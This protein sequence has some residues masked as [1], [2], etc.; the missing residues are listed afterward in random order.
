MT[1]PA[2]SP[3]LILLAHPAL[4]RSHANRALRDAAAVQGVT[5]HD[6]YEAYPSHDIEIEAEQDLVSRH[7]TVVMQHPFYWYSVPPI[8]KEWMDLVLQHGWAYG[9][10]G[11]ALHGK[12]FLNALTTGDREASYSPAR[13]NRYTVR[14]FLAPI[15]M[16]ARLCGME[17]LPPFVVHGTQG[18]THD[19]LLAHA[20]DYRRLL[21]AL[22]DGR[23]DAAAAAGLPRI[24]SDLD[25]VIAT[26]GSASVPI[27]PR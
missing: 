13:V 15:E 12:T 21:E 11:K 1:P 25:A 2:T 3:V 22:R 23:I 24:N 20:A 5:I 8:L 16:T 10:A 19:E 26:K 6:L 7:G 4:H 18:M 9:S 17:F 14:Q 27:E